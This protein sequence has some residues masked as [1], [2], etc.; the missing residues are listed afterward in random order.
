MK[1]SMPREL[2]FCFHLPP[3]LSELLAALLGLLCRGVFVGHYSEASG[4]GV[5]FWQHL[6]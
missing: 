2:S 5:V 4:V 3:A 6:K 1:F